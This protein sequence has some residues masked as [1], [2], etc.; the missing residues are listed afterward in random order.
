M[1]KES[2][3]FAELF[4]FISRLI[5]ATNWGIRTVLSGCPKCHF[6]MLEGLLSVIAQNGTDGMIYV[7]Q[8]AEAFRQS[9][10]AISRELRAMEQDGL[11][12]RITDPSDRRKTLVRVT[13]Q[14]YA[15]SAHCE[16]ALSRYFSSI[17]QRLTP[18]QRRQ[19][20]ELKDVLLAA[21]EAE[22]AE[23]QAKLKGEN[24]NG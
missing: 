18:E 3:D 5:G 12:E 22:N 20:N 21:V 6:A 15:A 16:Q 11:I 1:Q 14:G 19:C 23:Q 8:L 2:F 10:P 4:Q 24:E 9:M 7:S 17:G 13:E